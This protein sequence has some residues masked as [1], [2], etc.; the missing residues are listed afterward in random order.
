MTA[1][2]FV[3]GDWKDPDRA[4]WKDSPLFP[5]DSPSNGEMIITHLVAS[6]AKQCLSWGSLHYLLDASAGL[7]EVQPDLS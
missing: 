6:R 3:S 7:T 1:L 2:G 4:L 5:G